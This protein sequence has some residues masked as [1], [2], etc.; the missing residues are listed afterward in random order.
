MDEGTLGYKIK[1]LFDDDLEVPQNVMNS[2][3]NIKTITNREAHGK[4]KKHDKEYRIT[5]SEDEARILLRDLWLFFKWIIICICNNEIAAEEKWKE[6]RKNAIKK[7]VDLETTN[8]EMYAEKLSLSQLIFSKGYKFNIPTYQRDYTWDKNNIK[9]LFD[10]IVKRKDDAKAHYFGS[11]AIAI[12]TKKKIYRIIDG[13]QR[14]S[15]SLILFKAFYDV[16]LEKNI[17]VPKVLNDFIKNKL[18]SIYI[19]KDVL[20]SQKALSLL[21]K[22]GVRSQDLPKKPFKN[23]DYFYEKINNYDPIDIIELFNRFAMNFEIGIL[24]FNTTIENEMDIFENLNTGGTK[25]NDWDLIRNFIFSRIAP[26]LFL[27]EEDRFDKDL[28]NKIL[29]RFNIATNN[30]SQSIIN[31]FINVFNRLEVIKLRLNQEFLNNDKKELFKENYQIFKYVWTSK[32]KNKFKE[33]KEF[34]KAINELNRN[35]NIFISL[36]FPYQDNKLKPYAHIISLVSQRDDMMPLLITAAEKYCSLTNEGTFKKINK[37]FIKTIRILESYMI[38]SNI[39]GNNLKTYLDAYL[40][41]N[42]N[43]IAGTLYKELK[44]GSP[45]PFGTLDELKNKLSS[46]GSLNKGTIVSICTHLELIARDI[47]LG[48]SAMI[49]FEKSHEHIIAQKLKFSDYDDKNISNQDFDELI[50]T[51]INSI[52]N[53]LLLNIGDNVNKTVTKVYRSLEVSWKKWI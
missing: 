44:Q 5:L 20:S 29:V 46:S 28:N 36:K 2:L 9:K 6:R 10:D 11:L 34:N 4:Q 35:V 33:Y 49:N 32:Y 40:Y 8:K 50:N 45:V 3:Y 43:D 38:R 14:I 30:K 51:K 25:L 15:T 48:T 52:G 16:M 19:N 17:K 39:Y 42:M 1:Q 21:L 37:E 26:D 47:E 53:A 13:Q 27:E 22:G 24:I 41:K 18:S 12:D 7:D 23:Y 31:K